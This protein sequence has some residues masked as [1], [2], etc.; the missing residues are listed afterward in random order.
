[1]TLKKFICCSQQLKFHERFDRLGYPSKKARLDHNCHKI[2]AWQE[3]INFVYLKRKSVLEDLA[4]VLQAKL[5]A[6][7]VPVTQILSG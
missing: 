5:K 3:G 1:M 6:D 4:R 7:S 2:A